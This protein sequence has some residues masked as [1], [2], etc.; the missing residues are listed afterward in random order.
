MRKPT[1]QHQAVYLQRQW[2]GQE[3]SANA[4]IELQ[5]RMVE[6]GHEEV[7]GQAGGQPGFCHAHGFL[8]RASRWI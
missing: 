3:E 8:L 5:C 7:T 6:M 2:Y 1:M 4:T